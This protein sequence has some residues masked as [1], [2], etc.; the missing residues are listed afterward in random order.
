[1]KYLINTPIEQKIKDMAVCDR[2]RERMIAGGS[3]SLSDQEL[4][5]ILIGSG[6]RERSVTLIAK[7]LL[8]LM[9]K[10]STVTYEDLIGVPG[11]G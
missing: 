10:K 4:L 1:M 3:Q 11:L 7:D 8:E 5:A 9:D 6:N 2:P